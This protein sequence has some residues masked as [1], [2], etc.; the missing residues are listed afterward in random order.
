MPIDSEKNLLLPKATCCRQL[1]LFLHLGLLNGVT[2]FVLEVFRLNNC[3]YQLSSRLLVVG[4]A[5]EKPET[6]LNGEP[7]V[8]DVGCQPASQTSHQPLTLRPGVHQPCAPAAASP[9]GRSFPLK[10]SL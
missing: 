9:V 3:S 8:F 5:G 7:G 2:F 4:I 1:I 6:W 10:V